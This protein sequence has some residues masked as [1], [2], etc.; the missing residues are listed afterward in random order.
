MSTIIDR[1]PKFTQDGQR[2]L[3][4]FQRDHTTLEKILAT[5]TSPLFI[6]R[7]IRTMFLANDSAE[8]DEAPDP[9]VIV[10]TGSV[11]YDKLLDE[12]PIEALEKRRQE[13]LARKQALKENEA[14][15]KMVSTKTR[16]ERLKGIDQKPKF[17]RDGERIILLQQ[18]RMTRLERI[19][20]GLT[21]PLMFCYSL[22]NLRKLQSRSNY[23]AK[24]MNK[25]WKN[26]MRYLD[27][28]T[29]II[30]TGPSYYNDGELVD[31]DEV[32]TG[33]EEQCD[34]DSI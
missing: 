3:L 4:C 30:P 29:F 5:V 8:F 16:S 18:R 12:M 33:D 26:T 21:I 9:T 17:T 34:V 28:P 11:V 25:S 32:E 31:W 15:W 7:F 27:D 23:D 24:D 2:I 1:S 19:A 13:G 22:L 6:W 10:P 20:T 14:K